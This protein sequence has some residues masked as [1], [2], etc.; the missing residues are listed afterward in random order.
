MIKYFTIKEVAEMMGIHPVTVQN[1]IYRGEL[2]SVRDDFKNRHLISE[3]SLNN[4]RYRNPIYGGRGARMNFS[5]DENRPGPF[6]QMRYSVEESI[7][8][9][10]MEQEVIENITRKYRFE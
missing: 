9:Q 10:I 7:T 8:Y 5:M 4:F 3:E 6:N 2:E 1:L